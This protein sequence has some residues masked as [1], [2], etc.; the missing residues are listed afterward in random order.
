M[1][2]VGQVEAAGTQNWL[3]FESEDSDVQPGRS[4]EYEDGFMAVRTAN[5]VY[6]E[7]HLIKVKV[8]DRAGNSFE[9]PEVR[10]YVRHKPE[11]SP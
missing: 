4:L 1:R 9:T 7:G 2:D 5:G 6:F 11:D 3:G 8:S 10:V